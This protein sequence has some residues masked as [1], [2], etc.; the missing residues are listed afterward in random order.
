MSIW[1]STAHLSFWC[2]AIAWGLS[3]RPEAVQLFRVKSFHSCNRYNHLRFKTLCVASYRQVFFWMMN[4][5]QKERRSYS[6]ILLEQAERAILP[7]QPGRAENPFVKT[8]QALRIGTCKSLRHPFFQ[9][10]A[11]IAK[12]DIQNMMQSA[13]RGTRISARPQ[14][15]S[16]RRQI[17][18]NANKDFGSNS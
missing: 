9:N 8:S 1:G 10:L 17:R 6:P 12:Y 14:V 4:S 2:L 16:L 15:R 11:T 5:N 18:R 3:K 7:A 13:S